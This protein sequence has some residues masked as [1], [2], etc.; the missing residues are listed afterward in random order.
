MSKVQAASGSKSHVKQP[1]KLVNRWRYSPWCYCSQNSLKF[2]K[3]KKKG[4]C[5][6]VVASQGEGEKKVG[7]R[8][9]ENVKK[10]CLAL[11]VSRFSFFFALLVSPST[12]PLKAYHAGQV[13]VFNNR[14]KNNNK[15]LKTRSSGVCCLCTWCS[16]SVL[17]MVFSSEHT[18]F[19][20]PSEGIWTPSN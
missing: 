7:I 2:S 9:R 12:C 3:E 14:Q 13:I 16:A 11:L 15:T 8:L 1:V 17:L 4:T 19:S 5:S 10:S 6:L 20:W 18:I